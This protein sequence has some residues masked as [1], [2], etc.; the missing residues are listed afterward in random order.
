MPRERRAA[1]YV[2]CTA[3]VI[4]REGKANK[5]SYFM[6]VGRAKSHVCQQVS[7]LVVEDLYLKCFSW[8]SVMSSEIGEMSALFKG[9]TGN[10]SQGE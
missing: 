1:G 10:E 5:A 8:R 2:R 3:L 6:V 4:Q 9:T 7:N